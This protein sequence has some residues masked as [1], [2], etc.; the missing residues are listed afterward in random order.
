VGSKFRPDAASLP[1]SRQFTYG[2]RLSKIVAS[3]LA[4]FFQLLYHQFAWTYNFVARI[5]SSGMWF[6]WVN[7]ALPFLDQGPVLEIGFGTGYLL[8]ALSERGIYVIGLDKSMYMAKLSRSSLRKKRI[9]TELVNGSAQYLPFPP[10]HFQRIVST[11]PSPY[12]L[13]RQTLLE[14]WRVLLPGGQV[15]IIPSA[16]ITGV[17]ARNKLA[18]LLFRVTH[19]V[20]SNASDLD[21]VYTG[22]HDAMNAIGF[23]VQ[24]RIIELPQS[25][26]LCF[27]AGKPLLPV[28]S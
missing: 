5:V 7:T 9:I 23:E 6:Q 14:I 4:L 19:Q 17:S 24:Q 13:D 18:T 12:I 11:F 10:H 2:S 8:G 26:V 27:L 3:S 22:L 25:K 28:K 16:W 20:P 1:P 15:V 21:E